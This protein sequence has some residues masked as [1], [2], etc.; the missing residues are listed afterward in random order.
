LAS[1][2][3]APAIDAAAPVKPGESGTMTVDSGGAQPEGIGFGE[4]DERP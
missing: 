4:P 1:L 2:R 3:E